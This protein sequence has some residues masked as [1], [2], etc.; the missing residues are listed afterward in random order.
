MNPEQPKRPITE[1]MERYKAHMREFDAEELGLAVEALERSVENLEAQE[2]R[3]PD[4]ESDESAMYWA[5]L[6]ELK[7]LDA[8]KGGVVSLDGW[9]YGNA[10]NALRGMADTMSK[11]SP[12]RQKILDLADKLEK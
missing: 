1:G 5:V 11:D 2:R 9:A 6:R 8:E 7:K 4:N 10:V 3:D 12:D